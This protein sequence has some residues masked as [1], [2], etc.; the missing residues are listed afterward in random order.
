MNQIYT[1]SELKEGQKAKVV[2]ILSKG[3]IRRRLKEIGLIEGTNIQ[4]LQKSP[5]G[6]PVAFSIRGAVIA[7]RSE[8][9][10]QILIQLGL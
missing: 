6:D 7:L 8:D 2:K 3:R 4:C 1:M 5:S 9:S 10:R